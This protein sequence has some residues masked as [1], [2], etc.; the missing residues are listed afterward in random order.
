MPK[1]LDV[2]QWYDSS[3]AIKSIDDYSEIYTA[4][5]TK[6]SEVTVDYW[7]NYQSWGDYHPLEV[8]VTF[9][10]TIEVTMASSLQPIFIGPQ[11]A[12]STYGTI[13]YDSSDS[14]IKCT[15]NLWN[16][17]S[18][19][20]LYTAS[21]STLNLSGS[22]SSAQPLVTR[23]GYIYIATPNPSYL[24]NSIFSKVEFRVSTTV[25]VDCEYLY[26]EIQTLKSQI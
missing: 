22:V 5:T 6:W 12:G 17:Y 10:P 15:S 4:S 26:N 25:R 13:G 9:Q 23:N 18:G 3:G 14:S 7:L 21:G 16:N 1:F 20:T 2:P 24:L 8:R 19:N 11:P